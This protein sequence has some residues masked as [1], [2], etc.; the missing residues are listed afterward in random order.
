MTIKQTKAR[1]DIHFDG[2]S[3]QLGFVSEVDNRIACETPGLGECERRGSVQSCYCELSRSL[4]EHLRPPVWPK[5]RF[6]SLLGR[7]AGSLVAEYQG[8]ILFHVF[9]KPSSSLSLTE[10]L[11]GI[12]QCLMVSSPLALL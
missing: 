1:L 12:E 6:P 8:R 10:V 11:L 2:L 4:P 5:R 3:K 9:L 7:G